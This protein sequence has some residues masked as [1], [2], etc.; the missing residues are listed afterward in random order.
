MVHFRFELAHLTDNLSTVGCIGVV[1]LL[2]QAVPSEQAD[3]Q[4]RERAIR[5]LQRHAKQLG[6]T[7]IFESATNLYN[8]SG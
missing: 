5:Q 2:F 6:A 1:V 3:A 7:V 8:F 4:Y